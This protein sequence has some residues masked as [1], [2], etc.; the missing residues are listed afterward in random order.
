ML[1]QAVYKL[2][3]SRNWVLLSQVAETVELILE[4]ILQHINEEVDYTGF[5]HNFLPL[6]EGETLTSERVARFCLC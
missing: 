2:A 3:D 5:T 4:G 1:E 6:F